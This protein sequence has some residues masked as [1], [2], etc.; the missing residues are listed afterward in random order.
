[1]PML[2]RFVIV[3]VLGL[4]L[5]MS[6]CGGSVTPTAT[7][8]SPEPV[9][10]DAPI[11]EEAQLADVPVEP[12]AVAM[13][14][15]FEPPVG[16]AAESPSESPGHFRLLV[17][18]SADGLTF[19]PTGQLITDQASVPDM[20]INE[21]GWIYLYYTGWQVGE[22]QNETAAAISTDAGQS[23]VFKYVEF[24]GFDG[25]PPVDPDIVRLPD[26]TF[27]MFITSSLGSNISIWYAD[28]TDGLHFERRGEALTKEGE[29]V[30]DST[31]FFFNNMWHM[32]ALAGTTTDQWH[33]T[34]PD[35]TIFNA[36]DKFVFGDAGARYVA[37]NG[38]EVDNGYRLYS[39]SLGKLDIRS[40]FSTDG[41]N[42]TLEDGVRLA[43]DPNS[44]LED[45]YI[46]DPAVLRLADGTYLMVYVTR[47]PS[48]S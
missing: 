11:V 46:K 32:L 21:Q 45:S 31:T 3:G 1:M 25:A 24:G 14:A 47:I 6:A 19:T 2:R 16:L 43:H 7:P 22:R 27:R 42:W 35:G 12:G 13:T 30:I 48:T 29:N 4:S 36:P 23:W 38:V 28:S 8:L 33:G 39:F 44:P 18:T 9:E 17:A 15:D 41:S 20:L 26:G 5:Q 37:S 10:A 34:S 40:F